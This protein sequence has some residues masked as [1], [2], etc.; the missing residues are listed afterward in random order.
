VALALQRHLES[1][2]R[3]VRAERAVVQQLPPAAT[4]LEEKVARLTPLGFS[5]EA[6]RAALEATGTERSD[7]RSPHNLCP[8]HK[9]CTLLL[10]LNSVVSDIRARQDKLE[11][12]L[13]FL[14]SS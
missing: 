11:L 3:Q 14:P 9:S 12:N 5:A 7:R 10:E 6:C 4:E 13:N 8:M 2:P 1:A